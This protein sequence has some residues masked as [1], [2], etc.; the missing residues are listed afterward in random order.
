M[1]ITKKVKYENMETDKYSNIYQEA[2]FPKRDWKKIMKI[3]VIYLRYYLW[4][5]VLQFF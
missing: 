2:L 3:Y 5:Y 4:L 1:N